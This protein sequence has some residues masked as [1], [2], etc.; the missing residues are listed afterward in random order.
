MR[1]FDS[2]RRACRAPSCGRPRRGVG[3]RTMRLVASAL[4]LVATLLAQAGAGGPAPAL[5]ASS[6]IVLKV[7]GQSIVFNTSAREGTIYLSQNGYDFINPGFDFETGKEVSGLNATADIGL[8]TG[9][10]SPYSVAG[11]LAVLPAGATAAAPQAG[12]STVP[13]VNELLV[14]LDSKGHYVLVQI[15]AVTPDALTFLYSIGTP[16]RASASMGNTVWVMSHQLTFAGSPR[17]GEIALSGGGEVS[18]SPGF[19]FELDHQVDTLHQAAGMTAGLSNGRLVIGGYLAKVSAAGHAGAWPA[20]AVVAPVS[21]SLY[22][23]VD[24]AGNYVL[25]QVT[26]VSANAVMF[27]YLVLPARSVP[28]LPSGPV[29][30]KIGAGAVTFSGP[31][32]YGAI[33]ASS[34]GGVLQNPGFVLDSGKEVAGLSASPDIGL[35]VTSGK[36]YLHG[37][38]ATFAQLSAGAQPSVSD[39]AALPF[40]RFVAV[41]GAGRYVLIGVE[42]ATAQSVAFAYEIE[43]AG[44]TDVLQPPNPASVRTPAV[45]TGAGTLI[46]SYFTGMGAQATGSIDP[47]TGKAVSDPTILEQLSVEG[48]VLS[49]GKF[50]SLANASALEE[51]LLSPSGAWLATVTGGDIS[52]RS[53]RG[54]SRVIAQNGDAMGGGLPPMSWSPDSQYLAYIG[55]ATGSGYETGGAL[56]VIQPSSG[57]SRLLVSPLQGGVSVTWVGWLPGDRLVFSTGKALYEISADWSRAAELPV[58]MGVMGQNGRFNLSP[59]GTL[60]TWVAKGANGHYQVFVAT[61][62]GKQRVQFTNSAHDNWSPQFAP[63]STEVVYVSDTGQPPG[64]QMSYFTIDGQHHGTTS[65]SHVF[66]IDQW[67]YGSTANKWK[68]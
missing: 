5:A 63:N 58:R 52:V 60:V 35:K 62:D 67:S 38:E 65:I 40:G 8:E 21:G 37:L 42:S 41:D 36:T 44:A 26:G 54:P 33:V 15:T 12:A 68:G 39:V 22:L 25:L 49:T 55:M 10:A 61:L 13:K 24:N 66:D 50:F 31:A 3:P 6:P 47:A 32:R 27:S 43:S 18:V 30:L 57:K 48:V 17:G 16:E 46:Y 29:T 4:V 2:V 64:G 19:N 7:S 23:L 20:A 9:L 56:W 11:D 51:P 14:V 28:V 45:P 53:L 1:L 59:D 34:G